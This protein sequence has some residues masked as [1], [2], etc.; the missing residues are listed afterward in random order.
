M[1]ILCRPTEKITVALQRRIIRAKNFPR[2]NVRPNKKISVASWRRIFL[3]K[4]HPA[5]NFRL[6]GFFSSEELSGK[7]FS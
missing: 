5:K 7:E 1:I 6:Q 4:N 2:K 3:A